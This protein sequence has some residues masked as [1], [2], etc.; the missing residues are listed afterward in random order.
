MPTLVRAARRRGARPRRPRPRRGAALAAPERAGRPPP[1][2][3][4]AGLPDA[5]L[6]EL[7][8]VLADLAWALY[9]KEGTD[10]AA[11]GEP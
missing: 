10:D 1:S 11:P 9:R 8:V 7:A 5:L 2:G 3:P 6:P 4:A